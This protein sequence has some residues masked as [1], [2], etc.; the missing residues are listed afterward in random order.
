M[1]F[2]LTNAPSTFQDMMNHIFWDMIDMG[3][4]A[5]MDDLLIYADTMEGHNEII[6]K[7]LQRF[8]KNRLAISPEKCVWR[9]QEV[10]FLGYLIGWDGIKMSPDK[11]EAVLQWKSP[12]SLVET[13]SFLGLLTSIDDSYRTTRR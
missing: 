2:G 4:L 12:S 11:V 9:T 7:V 3:L 10:E 8:T 1:P 6:Q 5:Y 13:Q